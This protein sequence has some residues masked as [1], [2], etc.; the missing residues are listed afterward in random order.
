MGSANS[1]NRHQSTGAKPTTDDLLSM[2]IRSMKRRGYFKHEDKPQTMTWHTRDKE[3]GSISYIY[4]HTG[5]MVQYQV[6][7]QQHRYIIPIT[8]T[9]CYLG[10]WREWFSCPKCHKRVAILYLNHR[11]ACR[12]CNQ[13]VYQSTRETISTVGVLMKRRDRIAKRLGLDDTYPVPKPKGMHR[14]TFKRLQYEHFELE[15]EIESLLIPYLR[16]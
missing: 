7:N 12:K 15:C 3:L 5:L 13:L 1:G 8:I 2:D 6:G 9:P 11:F 16:L 4:S 14:S 10:G